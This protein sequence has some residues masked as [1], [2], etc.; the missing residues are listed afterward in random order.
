MESGI[1]IDNN[2]IADPWKK[3]YSATDGRYILTAITVSG[4]VGTR[5]ITDYHW[6]VIYTNSDKVYVPYSALSVQN[7]AD[8][9]VQ[10]SPTIYLHDN[11]RRPNGTYNDA[12]YS[13]SGSF[14]ETTSEGVIVTY[15]SATNQI[16][17]YIPNNFDPICKHYYV[18]YSVTDPE[19]NRMSGGDFVGQVPCEHFTVHIQQAPNG[20]HYQ[21]SGKRSE[22]GEVCVI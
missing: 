2:S 18:N 3:A 7:S 21:N 11:N 8:E 16:Q 15:N 9:Y 19:H 22:Y 14:F 1:T 6:D 5:R 17:Y 10:L 4:Y 20:A 13:G 12:P